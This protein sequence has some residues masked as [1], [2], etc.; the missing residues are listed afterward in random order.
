M[1]DRP[2]LVFLRTVDSSRGLDTAPTGASAVAVAGVVA[3]PV[4]RRA[5]SQPGSPDFFRPHPDRGVPAD[6][7]AVGHRDRALAAAGAGRV[8]A[9]AAGRRKRRA[10]QPFSTVTQRRMARGCCLRRQP[11]GA[12]GPASFQRDLG[13]DS[14]R[15]LFRAI[16]TDRRTTRGPCGSLRRRAVGTDHGRTGSASADRTDRRPLPGL[17]DLQPRLVHRPVQI[18]PHPPTK[19]SGLGRTPELLWAG[20]VAVLPSVLRLPTR[21]RPSPPNSCSTSDRACFDTLLQL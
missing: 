1:G 19:K 2:L 9:A 4:R 14:L 3:D 11:A 10:G 8:A 6:L 18:D 12:R 5:G 17:A 21:R 20:A 7:R 15:L 16:C 13:A